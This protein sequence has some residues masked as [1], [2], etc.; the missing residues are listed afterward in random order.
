MDKSK[1]TTDDVAVAAG[2]TAAPNEPAKPGTVTLETPIKR[3]DQEITAISLRKPASGELRGIALADL[4]R[5]DVAAL[6]T[7][8][9]RITSPTLTVHEASQ[10]DLVDLTA[11]GTEVLGFF[12]SKADKAAI[13]PSPI[14]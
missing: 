5:L 13:S 9:P 10:L 12:V 6:I 14:A 2:G 11:L 3:G 8:L 7:V 4:L 1:S